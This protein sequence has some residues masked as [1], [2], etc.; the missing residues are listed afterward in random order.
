MKTYRP[1]SPEQSYLLPPSPREWLPAGHLAYFILGLLGELD[2]GAIER[3]VQA[4]DPRGERPYS[5]EMMTSLL[6]YAYATGVYSSRRIARAC[7]EDVAFRVLAAGEQPHFT[8]INQF[9]AK[10]LDA[11]SG[12][13]VQVV[14]ACQSEGLVRLGHVA[15]DGTKMKANASKHKAM[16]HERMQ[17]DE[18]RLRAEI[19]EWFERAQAT[20]EE[21]DRLERRRRH[22]RSTG[23]DPSARGAAGEDGA[24]SRSA[25]EGSR[26][27][28][29]G[30]APRAGGGASQEGRGHDPHAGQAR[31]GCHAGQEAGPAGESIR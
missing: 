9:R 2:L 12:L 4:K 21:E 25:E 29:R 6:L 22:V 31:R 24:G 14:K 7:V 28:P 1:Y 27:G 16:S 3:A 18:A 30:S 11:L 15:I 10:H 19:Q 17:K 8:T 5:P 26:R 20:D 13:F 23:G